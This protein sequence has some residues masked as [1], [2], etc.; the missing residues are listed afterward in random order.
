MSARPAPRRARRRRTPADDALS[1]MT[2]PAQ[3]ERL[4]GHLRKLRLLKSGERL[5]ALLQ[6]AASRELPYAEFL[7]QVLGEEVAAK[8]SKNI[9][10]RTAMAR[11]P[12]VKPLETFDFGYQPSIDRKQLQQLATCHYIEHGDNVIVLGPPGVGKTHLAVSLG[13]KAIEAGYRVLFTTAAHLIAV[14]TKAH[15]EGRLDEK[16]KVYTTPRLLIIDEIG[17]LPIDRLGANLFF[18]LISRRYE[19]GPMILT[20]NQSFGAWGEVFGDRV[21]AT[22]ILDRLLHHAVTLNIRG[23]SYRLKEKLKA[24]LVRPQHDD[25][26][27]STGVRNLLCKLGLSVATD[28]RLG[29]R[30]LRSD[31]SGQVISGAYQKFLGGNALVC[32]MSAVG[33]CADNAACEGFFGM[34]K[35]ERVNHRKYRT[36]GLALVHLLLDPAPAFHRIGHV[37]LEGRVV[38]RP[39]GMEHLEQRGHR[40][41]DALLV[42]TFHGRA[43]ADT[44]VDLL[45]AVG[46]AK[47][48][49][50]RLGQ[51]VG[52]EAVVVGQE[53][54]A[55]LGHLP[56]GQIAGKAVHDRQVEFLGSGMN[57]S[58]SVE[59]TSCSMEWSMLPTK[60]MLASA[61]TSTPREKRPLAM[62][63]F[64][65]WIVSGSRI[66]MPGHLVEGD[67]V[68]EADQAD[69]P[70]GVVV[71]ERRLA[72]L[73]AAHQRGVGRELAEEVGLAR[74]AR[75]QFD[76]V[77]V[78]LDQRRQ[79]GDEVELQ[80]R[81]QLGRLQPHRAQDDVQ[82]FVAGEGAPA[83]RHSPRKSKRLSW[84]GRRSSM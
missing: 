43:E 30:I 46:V 2:T 31:R 73:P 18:Q 80:P 79:A 63:S 78:R 16:L 25:N 27:I 83:L 70:P 20:S 77:E 69:A 1:A 59:L 15:A 53:V 40:L 10:M 29:A 49:V 52:D 22:A 13:L 71:E 17:Y 5:E 8:A 12:F 47:L 81:R 64:M 6:E 24:G 74:A 82:P 32:S 76:E 9:A 19:R 39:V 45:V 58:C 68:P 3:L 72:G 60:A 23:N 48:V 65:I 21:I 4:G 62:K 55:V 34:L 66:L 37:L 35:R 28:G 42:A 41:L 67:R 84:I 54:A 61:M 7:E 33:H 51:V 38:R 26:P 36:R 75:P 14:L 11:F 44:L 50:E 57:R 56:A